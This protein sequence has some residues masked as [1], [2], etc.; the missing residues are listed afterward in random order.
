MIK[1][2][3]MEKKIV[4]FLSFSYF[5]AFSLLISGGYVEAESNIY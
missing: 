2:D 5:K 3:L 4:L 1:E